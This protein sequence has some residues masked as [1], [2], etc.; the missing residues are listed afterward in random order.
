MDL[1]R[2][3]KK[4]GSDVALAITGRGF[5]REGIVE[6]FPVFSFSF[7]KWMP[8]SARIP[9]SALRRLQSRWYSRVLQQFDPEVV[10]CVSVNQSVLDLNSGLSVP[11]LAHIHA[12][13]YNTMAK[14]LDYVN[15]LASFADH[16]V[17]SSRK[18]AEII[19]SCLGVPKSR[20]SMFHNGVPVRRIENSAKKGTVSRGSLGFQ[21]DDVVVV[22]CGSIDY[23]K[24]PDL[25]LRVAEAL[26]RLVGKDTPWRFVWVGDQDIGVNPFWDGCVNLIEAADLGNRCHFVGYQENVASYFALADIF[27]LTSRAESI[28]LAMMEAMALGTPVVTFP[29]GGVREVL[30]FGGGV[31]SR[32]FE[33]DE[34]GGAVAGLIEDPARRQELGIQAQ[35][36]IRQRFD[37]EIRFEKFELF[38]RQIGDGTWEGSREI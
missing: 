6:S 36:I 38:L 4:R 28:P 12:A 15:K 29:V 1:I 8:D 37:S 2:F 30:S 31:V 17:G 14:G 19:E 21:E 22:G 18:V 13:H 7:P 33:T 32:E 10:H 11:V 16:Y 9:G 26:G 27:L 34:L 3:L 23:I 24:G 5:H 35:Q 25:F 20:V